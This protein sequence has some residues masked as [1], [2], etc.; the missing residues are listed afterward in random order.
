MKKL[1]L[2]IA[3]LSIMLTSH[4][5]NAASVDYGPYAEILKTYVDKKGLVDYVGLKENREAFDEVIAAFTD[6][7]IDALS[8]V[9]QKAFWINAYNAY[10]LKLI[11]DRYPL[12]F[13]GILTINWGRPWNIEMKVAGRD[14]TLGEIEHEILRK[15]DPPDPR[16]HFAINCASIGCPILPQTPFYVE[17]LDA[18]LDEEARKFIN[19]PD[20]VRLDR[21]KQMLYHSAIFKWF[22]EDY[23]IDGHTLKSYIA[24]YM[25]EA[26]QTYLNN[27]EVK[28]KDLRYDWGLNKQEKQ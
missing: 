26:D 25:T 9:E 4:T 20:K 24:Q 5:V 21:E 8:P 15:L 27:N 2:L 7:D 12:R 3:T 1:A 22:E 18:Q 13:G 11:I 28:L 6:T 17:T 16:I 14:I 23:L 19:N 10:T